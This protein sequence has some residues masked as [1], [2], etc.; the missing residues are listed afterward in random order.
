[1]DKNVWKIEHAKDLYSHQSLCFNQPGHVYQL[2]D[3]FE[4]LPN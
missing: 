3:I 4:T 2:I 1:M